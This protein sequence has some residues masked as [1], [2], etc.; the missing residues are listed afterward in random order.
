MGS[1]SCV[2]HDAVACEAVIAC[3]LLAVIDKYFVLV[4]CLEEAAHRACC[5]AV[6]LDELVAVVALLQEDGGVILLEI[7]DTQGQAVKALLG[8]AGFT[9]TRVICD[10]AGR[11]RVVFGLYAKEK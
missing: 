7:G 11:D 2:V 8:G 1:L 6:L 5:E 10:L 3:S 4:L 9:R